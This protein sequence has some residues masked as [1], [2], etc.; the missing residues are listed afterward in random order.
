MALVALH[1]SERQQALD[2]GIPPDRIEIIPNGID[3]SEL[4]DLLVKGTFR[5]RFGL[6]PKRPVILFLSRINKKNGA[7]MLVEAFARLYNPDAQL[8][9]VG[10]DDGH[11]ADV[12]RL[13][14]KY[15]MEKQVILP[16]RLSGADVLSAFQDADLFV[17]PCRADTFPVTI[18]EACL[19][20]TPM[21]VTNCCEIAH[22][23]KD[24]VAEVVPFDVGEFAG[25]MNR[26]L[27]N[28]ELYE[29]YRAN[30]WALIQSTFSIQAVVNQL[31]TVY[32]RVIAK[33]ARER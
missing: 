30:C 13:I 9:I 11:L 1:E 23:V 18:I 32:Q 20:G 28:R 5:R 33:M 2:H 7:D 3:P 21:V 10:P 25:A 12:Q 4:N 15:Q 24:L 14:A 8:A 6:D 22:L 26:L 19:V 27:T 31:E 17:L 29:H 16:G